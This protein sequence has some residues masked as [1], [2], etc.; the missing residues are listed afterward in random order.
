MGAAR[1]ELGGNWKD[2]KNKK[3]VFFYLENFVPFLGAHAAAPIR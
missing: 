1:V 2:S 3:R